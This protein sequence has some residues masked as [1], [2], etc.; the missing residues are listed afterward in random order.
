MGELADEIRNHS[1][2]PSGL[3]RIDMVL[4][5]LSPEDRDDLLA[6]LGDVTVAPSAIVA[7]L[8]RRGIQLHRDRVRWYRE[9]RCRGVE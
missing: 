4:A 5:Q 1:T 3:T 6:A 8:R 9:D 7:V 2:T